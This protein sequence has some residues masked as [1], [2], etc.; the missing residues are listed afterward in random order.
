MLIIGSGIAISIIYK[1]KIVAYF[2]NE[3][4]KYI[5]IPIDVKKINVSIFSQFPSISVDLHQVTV[6]ESSNEHKAILGQANLISVAF[7][8]IDILNKNYAIQGI[9]I[10]DAEVNLRIDK[11]GEAN[12]LLIKKDSTSKKR[13]LSL[14]HITAEKINI[15]Y[16]DLKSNYHVAFFAKDAKAQLQQIENNIK[17]EFKGN[18]LSD[19]IRVNERKFLNNKQIVLNTQLEVDLKQ[20]LYTFNKGELTIDKGDFEITGFVDAL[21]KN[22]DLKFN[23]VNTNFQSINTL[24]S[25]DLS[26]YLDEYRSKGNVY[27]TG[28]VKGNYSGKRSVGVNLNFGAKNTSFYHP[29]YKKQIT[30][31][32]V[33]GSFTTGKN[34]SISSYR[35]DLKNFS[36]LLE[37][38][39]L[40]GSLALKNF[41]DYHLDLLLVGEAD[42]N[43]LLL[44]FPKEYVKTAFGNIKMDI[45]INGKLKDPKLTENINANGEIEFQNVSLVLTGKKLPL[46]KLNGSLILRNNDLAVSNFSGFVGNSD[47]ML[48]GFIK[49]ISTLISSKNQKYRMQADLQSHHID[50]DELLKSNFASRDTT[51]I[52]TSMYKFSISPKIFLDFNCEIQDIKFKR[53]RGRTIAGN[54]E[55]K[56]QIAVLNNISFSSMGGNVTMSGSVN[57]KRKNLVETISETTLNNINIDSIFYVFK[58]FNQDWLVDKNLKGQLDADI[59]LY[60]NFNENLIL[61]GQSMVADINMSIANGELNDFEPMMEL[62]KF[63]EEESLEE[64]RFS[65]MTNKIN[66]E[67]RTIFLPEMEIR[68]NV[69]NILISGTH[70][71][72]NKI[73][74]HLSVPLKSFIRISRKKGYNKSAR[75]GMNLLLKLTGHTS[76]YKISYDSQALKENFKKDFIDERQEWKNIK[77]KDSVIESEVPELEE[78]YFDF[79]DSE[80]DSTGINQ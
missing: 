44:L 64:M 47:F 22:I 18:L 72:G 49:D 63:V 48:N 57:S 73:D 31:V 68:S 76:D 4:N 45:H 29:D 41:K 43:T 12:Y 11:N 75:Q 23:G 13:A 20:K 69:S 67:N 30:G 33:E 56:N 62:S 14:Q 70:T 80:S 25:S 58:N 46:N 10:K 51:A 42:V 55:I 53:F 7:N 65:K 74:Y 5:A 78:E 36:C 3:S 16:A 8:P 39:K 15:D 19:E 79:E 32:S 60:M 54:V 66:I 24:L 1:D 21:E 27:F 38:K 35:L 26:K 77:K 50:F 40:E 59:N 6:K 2:L 37:D 17:V 71:F 61:N 34:K 52:K 28:D 9:H